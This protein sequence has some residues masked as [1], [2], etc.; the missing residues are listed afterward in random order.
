MQQDGVYQFEHDK[1]REAILQLLEPEKIVTIQFE[2]GT[3]LLE[4]LA[5]TEI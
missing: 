4:E 3:M 1:L 5:P 2:V